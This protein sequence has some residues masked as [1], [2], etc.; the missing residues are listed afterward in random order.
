MPSPSADAVLARIRAQLPERA[1]TALNAAETL[2][3]ADALYIVGGTVRDALLET[4]TDGSTRTAHAKPYTRDLDLLVEGGGGAA[5]LG[6]AL[7]RGLGGSLTCHGAFLTSTLLW[8]GLEVDL[9]TTRLERYPY[10]GALPV[11]SPAPL[12]DDLQRR[13][14]SVNTFSLR[15]Y[16]LPNRLFYVA[17]ALDDLRARRLRTLH[18]ASFLDDPTRIVRGSR[19]AGRLGL[20][21]D[22]QTSTVLT[23]ALEA[24]A[25]RQVS[26][27]RL[28]RELLLTLAEPQVAPAFEHLAQQDALWALYGLRATSLL[29]D[30]D[31]LRRTSPVPD[32]SYLL[33][34][35]SALGEKE[36]DAHFHLFAWPKRLLGARRRLLE[37]LR[38]EALDAPTEAERCVLR[39]ARPGLSAQFSRPLI[40]GEDVLDLGLPAGPEVGEVLRAVS[41][42]RAGG[43]VT[44]LDDERQ[45]ASK[46]VA[47]IKD[48]SA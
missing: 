4:P 28:K 36:L 41:R 12:E 43:Q 8:R 17:G 18:P 45:L 37:A 21:Y 9:S 29:S 33:A 15:L 31:A 16:P 13:D 6:G 25:Y 10:P 2:F 44:S 23:R 34:L 47:R 35:L 32:E 5:G 1:L 39:A 40:R 46:L 14:F 27:E 26:A 20:E 22:A 19:L 38:G 3:A 48:R 24:G 30:L 7:E 11:V 42:A